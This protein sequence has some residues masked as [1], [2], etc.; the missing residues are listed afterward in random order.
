MDRHNLV[1]YTLLEW[2]RQAAVIIFRRNDIMERVLERFLE[3]VRFNTQSDEYSRLHPSTAVQM[4]F[5]LK[6]KNELEQLKI[7]DV[8][9]DEKSYL[10][11]TLPANT[12]RKLPVIG[13]IAHMDTS[14]EISG[15]DVNPQ[16]ISNY[17]GSDIILNKEAN[18]IL[19]P[20]EYPDLLRFK[21]DDIVVTDGTTL[22]GADD[23]AGVAEIIT[24]I[25]YLK[26][27]PQIK[28]GKIRIGFTPD[29]EIG[30]GADHFDVA[31]FG[32]DF[33]YTM[34]GDLLGS[35]EYEN[36]NAAVAKIT[37]GGR[38]I[39]PGSAKNKMINSILIAMEIISM[40]PAFETPSHTEGYEGFYHINDIKGAIEK[41]EL[42]YLIRDHDMAAF[43]GRKHRLERIAAYLNEKYG[44]GTVNLE[45]KDQYYNMKE[46]ITPNMHIIERAQRA[47]A[48]AGV[49]PVVKPVR[50]GTDGAR[51]SYNGL[52][53][54][55]LFTGGSNFH[56]KYEYIPVGSMKKA[57]EVILNIVSEEQPG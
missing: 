4:Q 46:K 7:E 17:D 54:P 36:F 21:G 45:I 26:N 24:A 12:E 15:K 9:V 48:K 14:P 8:E 11:A 49:T 52:P 2:R 19:S 10:T 31:R 34:D 43:N 50:G 20:S 57:V 51:L 38:S 28:H 29:E 32:A 39:H 35:L 13:L 55:N 30:E 22:L 1:L 47:M 6:L 33:A 18:I 23:K 16:I 25:E 44:P 42:K 41:T 3:Y 37:V 53:T 56:G 27:N 5:A 40:L